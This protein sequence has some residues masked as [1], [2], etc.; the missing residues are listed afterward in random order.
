[1]NLRE[2]LNKLLKKK[3]YENSLVS[4]IDI[5]LIPTRKIFKDNKKILNNHILLSLNKYK[6]FF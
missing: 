4:N 1:M 6:R 2:F 5:T 3:K